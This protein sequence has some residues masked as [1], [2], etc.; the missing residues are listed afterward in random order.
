MLDTTNIVKHLLNTRQFS[1]HWKHL[2]EQNKNSC[3]CG[4]YILVNTLNKIVSEGGKGYVLKRQTKE[5]EVGSWQP[6]TV[7]NGAIGTSPISV[8]L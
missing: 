4:T 7:L 6:G 8:D 5:Q 3:L 1:R 2:H